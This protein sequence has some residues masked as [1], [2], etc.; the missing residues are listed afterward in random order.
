M[1]E[2]IARRVLG[3]ISNVGAAGAPV[4]GGVHARKYAWAWKAVGAADLVC[5]SVGELFCL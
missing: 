2:I 5:L 1:V 3:G 4:A